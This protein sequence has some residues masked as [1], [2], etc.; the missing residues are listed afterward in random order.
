MYTLYFLCV[1]KNTV[2]SI[3]IEANTNWF[4]LIFEHTREPAQ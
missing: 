3:L 2:L 4:K 1:Y